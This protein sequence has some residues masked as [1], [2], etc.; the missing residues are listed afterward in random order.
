MNTS[1]VCPRRAWA[2]YSAETALTA[3]EFSIYRLIARTMQPKCSR[4]QNTHP[5]TPAPAKPDADQMASIGRQRGRVPR[6]LGQIKSA[7][8]LFT[9]AGPLFAAKPVDAAQWGA[10]LLYAVNQRSVT[11]L[12]ILQ[13]P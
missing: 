12:A 8:Q 10:V 4:D 2:F 1:V 5:E 6:H 13:D 3:C 11:L 9:F 7:S